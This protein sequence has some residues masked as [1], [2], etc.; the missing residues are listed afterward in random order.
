[1]QILT[2]VEISSDAVSIAASVVE[3][4][5]DGGKTRDKVAA[6]AGV[7]GRPLLVRKRICQLLW[8]LVTKWLPATRGTA[9]ISSRMVHP[10]S[11]ECM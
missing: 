7:S 1:L 8:P 10:R 4:C 11:Y 2:G 5:H 6:F 9:A 3:T